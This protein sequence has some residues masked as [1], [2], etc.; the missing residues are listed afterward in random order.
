MGADF[1]R[2]RSLTAIPNHVRAEEVRAVTMDP[3]LAAVLYEQ[4]IGMAPYVS[5]TICPPPIVIYS[6]FRQLDV[7]IAY[8][9]SLM[10]IFIS[11][12]SGSIEI[13]IQYNTI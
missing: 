12:Q 1:Q 4:A 10:V 8:D 11:P 13:I 2:I 6:P 3:N 9:F 5:E 7:M